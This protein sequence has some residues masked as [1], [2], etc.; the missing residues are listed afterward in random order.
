MLHDKVT[1]KISEL[2]TNFS[3]T[4]LKSS[5]IF[6]TLKSLISFLLHIQ[7]P[8]RGFR[9]KISQ[10]FYFTITRQLITIYQN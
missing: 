9:G 6:E 5:A 2:Q 10:I 8:F 7:V 4:Q 1:E 3:S